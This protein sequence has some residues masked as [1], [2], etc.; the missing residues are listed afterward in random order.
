MTRYNS[1]MSF[2]I[3]PQLDE[4]LNRSLKERELQLVMVRMVKVGT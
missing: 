1:G 3:D 4:A 2:G